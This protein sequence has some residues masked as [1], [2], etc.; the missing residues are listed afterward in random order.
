MN[1]KDPMYYQQGDV[2]LFKINKQS[3]GKQLDTKTVQEGEHTGHAHRLTQDN[4][5]LFSD[6]ENKHLRVLAGGDSL[7]HEEHDTEI[8]E[9]GE[10]E[11]RIVRQMDPWSKLIS[12]VVD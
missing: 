9:E 5:I 10:Y 12:K 7:T 2:L 8:I 6:G 3:K 11:V 1:N 4:S